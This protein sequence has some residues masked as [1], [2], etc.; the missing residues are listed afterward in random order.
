MKQSILFFLVLLFCFELKSQETFPI[1]GI[2]DHRQ[3]KYLIINAKIV[4]AFDQQPIDGSILIDKGKIIS[5]QTGNAVVKDAI[6]VDVLGNY[7]YPSFIETYATYGIEIPRKNKPGFE[8]PQFLSE[9]QGAYHWNESLKPETKAA[10][11]FI[12]NADQSK[13]FISNGFGVVLTHVND[14]ISRG[15]GVLVTLAN[16]SP[17]EVILKTEASNQLAFRRGASTQDYP[18]SLMGMVALLRQMYYDGQWYAKNPTEK[19][20]S[21]EA[22]N[23]LLNLPTI[24]EAGGWENILRADKI[25]DEFSIQY[26]IKGAGNEY[27]RIEEIKKTNATLIVPVQLP[28]TLDVENPLDADKASL[29]ELKHWELA[30]YNLSRLFQAKI[31]FIITSSDMKDANDFLSSVT[32]QVKNGLPV[33]EA[34]KALTYTPAKALGVDNQLGRIQKDFLANFIIC[35]GPLFTD[36]FQVYQNWIAGE[37][38]ILQPFEEQSICGKYMFLSSDYSAEM[39]LN[40]NGGSKLK[41]QDSTEIDID[42]LVTPKDLQMSFRFPD[43]AAIKGYTRFYGW[44]SGSNYAGW[45]AFSNGDYIQTSIN[46]IG[47]DTSACKSVDKGKEE[48]KKETPVIGEVIFPFVAYGWT[49]KPMAKKVLFKNATVWTNESQ[50]ILQETDVLI[51]NGKIVSIGKNLPSGNAVIVDA[52]GK[53]LTSGIIDEHSHIAVSGGVNEGTQSSSAEVRIG[54]VVN[55]SDINIYRQLSGGVVISQLLHGSANPIG[56]QS[57]IIKLRW[58]LSPEEMKMKS[59]PGFIKFALGENVKQ[60]NWGDRQTERFPQ[61]RMG[62][63]QVYMDYFTQAQ[64][65]NK[66]SN[67]RVDLELQALAEVLNKQRFITCHSYV[68]SEINMLMKVAEHF[69]FNINTFTHILEGYKVADIM[70]KHGVG[71]S[72]FSDWWAYKYEVIEAIPQNPC[73]LNE[74]GIITAINSDDAEMGRRLNQEAAKSIKYCGMSEEDAW[75]MVTLNPAK[76]LHID[77]TTGSILPGKDAD[78]VLWSDNPLSIYA[79]AEQTYVDG[80]K[81]FDIEK[82]KAMQAWM[83]QER[84]RIIQKMIVDK[85]SGAPVDI[86]VVKQEKNYHCDDMEIY[87]GQ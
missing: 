64:E 25:G 26:L 86:P 41:M 53:H 87:D 46:Y 43:S 17:H 22:W 36:T 30:P 76:L 21:L 1:N 12:P 72:T 67:H 13:S 57:A 40:E 38:H 24:F 31:P 10:D 4:T 71:A 47:T 62:V 82:D 32:K 39:I 19:N 80:I 55:C 8:G 70:K 16:K 79:K 27:Q 35:K 2:S 44:K 5:V 9:K 81:Y 73:I 50:G 23:H 52:T 49:E 54:D 37:Q 78:L 85:K 74:M 33:S 34:I 60:S 59:A 63:E 83:Q 7:V 75:K 66:T 18:S 84:E 20:L 3:E 77:Q 6:I 58:G 15:S 65:Y 28:K 48:Q 14:G 61:T 42:L 45:S 68:Q 69:H 11:V 29:S 51:D 56:G